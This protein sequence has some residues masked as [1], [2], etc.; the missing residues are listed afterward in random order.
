MQPVTEA[1]KLDQLK[2]EHLRQD[3]VLGLHK[4]MRGKWRQPEKLLVILDR[5]GG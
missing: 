2:E 3:W 1:L 5:L 4:K